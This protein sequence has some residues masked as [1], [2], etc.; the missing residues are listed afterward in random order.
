MHLCMYLYL[1]VLNTTKYP[2]GLATLERTHTQTDRQTQ[3]EQTERQ[4]DTQTHHIHTLH[5][6]KRACTHT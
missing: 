1:V 3:T 5:T 6:H 2:K 4:I